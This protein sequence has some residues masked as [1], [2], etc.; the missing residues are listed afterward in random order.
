MSNRA[1][2]GRLFA[3]SYLCVTAAAAMTLVILIRKDFTE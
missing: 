2:P 1:F 3:A